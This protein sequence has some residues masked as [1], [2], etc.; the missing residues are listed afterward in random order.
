MTAVKI[1]ASELQAQA[2]IF[3]NALFKKMQARDL[4]ISDHWD[5]DHLCFR[6]ESQNAYESYKTTFSDL[7]VLLTESHV[8]GR[9]IAT[10]ELHTA[11]QYK[12]WLIRLIE[13]PAPKKGKVTRAGFEHIEVVVDL[14]LEEIME[15]HSTIEWDTSGLEKIFNSELEA[16]FGESAV[17]FHHVS[18]KSV[19]NFE[20]RPKIAI[21]VSEL[22]LLEMF[23][24][25]Q[26]FIAG[27]FPLAIETPSADIDFLVTFDDPNE[28]ANQCKEGF[29]LLPEFEISTGEIHNL[30]YSL[31]RFEYRGV[32]VEIFCSSLSTYRQNAFLHFQAEEKILKYGPASWSEQV[33][34]LKMRGLKTE[35]AFAHLLNSDE[36]NA[37]QLM[38]ELQKRP[39]AELRRS[40]RSSLN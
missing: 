3:L 10:F 15:K 29:G 38:L 36:V 20:Q 13:L 17:K 11:I 31:C 25:H 27:T 23:K 9:A 18:L 8:N 30:S 28:F 39:I 12:D 4:K 22:K 35:P 2:E 14:P 1:S 26:P 34:Q 6:V 32:P 5:I 40:I 21:V 16:N 33:I 24:D 7:G 19:I 37:Y